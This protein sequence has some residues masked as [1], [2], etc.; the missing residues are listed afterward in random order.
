MFA[1]AL[2]LGVSCAW[3]EQATKVEAITAEELQKQLQAGETKPLLIDVRE[4]G[5]YEAV[6]I[7]G[8]LLAPL[9]SVTE[10]L[11]AIDKNQ[12]IVLV[13][14]SGRRSA[15]AYELLRERGFTALKNLDGGM[16]RWESLGYPVVKKQDAKP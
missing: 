11:E 13:C 3:A 14:R 4:P 2:V 16:L 12:R 10:R 7:D 1:L 8:A 6:H 9:G 15:K 5:E